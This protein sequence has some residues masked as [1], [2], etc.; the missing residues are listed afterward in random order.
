MKGTFATRPG[1]EIFNPYSHDSL[2]T[3]CCSVV[4]GPLPPRYVACIYT[5][6]MAESVLL[7]N[8][9]FGLLTVFASW[10]PFLFL[11]AF[12]N[13]RQPFLCEKYTLT[14]SD[15]GVI[16]TFVTILPYNEL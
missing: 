16:M 8:C 11:K 9:R 3:N 12:S 15:G 14:G 13:V 10:M 7:A 2:L 1:Q 4:C 5:V 6:F